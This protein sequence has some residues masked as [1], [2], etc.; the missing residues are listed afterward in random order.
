MIK[1][2]LFYR[3]LP[4]SISPSKVSLIEVWHECFKRI[5]MD[6]TLS[7]VVREWGYV[8]LSGEDIKLAIIKNPKYRTDHDY[9]IKRR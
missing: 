4:P 8:N 2:A 5:P 6:K 3:L 7:S 1:L 9:M